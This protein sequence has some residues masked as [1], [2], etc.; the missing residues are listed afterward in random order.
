MKKYIFLFH[1]FSLSILF[2]QAQNVGI[3]TGTP[4]EKLHVIGNIKADT[5]KPNA[6]K[7]TTAAGANKVLT[8]DACNRSCT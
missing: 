2:A 5:L 7:I 6:L 4:A 3:G 1:F 8:S